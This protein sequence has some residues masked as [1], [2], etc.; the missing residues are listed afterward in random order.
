MSRLGRNVFL[1]ALSEGLQENFQ[2]IVSQSYKDYYSSVLSDPLNIPFQDM[3]GTFSGLGE[4]LNLATDPALRRYSSQALADQ[5]SA[6]GL[7]TF[8]LSLLR[9]KVEK[10]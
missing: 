9:Q 1:P 2:E 5:F 4:I 10:K 3:K 8:G 6:Q 7:E